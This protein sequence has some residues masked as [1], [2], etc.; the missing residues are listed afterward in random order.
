MT[1]EQRAPTPNTQSTPGASKVCAVPNC[2]GGMLS[3]RDIRERM[4]PPEKREEYLDSFRKREWRK[5]DG[6]G[7]EYSKKFVIDPFALYNLTPFSY[8][9]SIGDQVFSIQRPGAKVYPLDANSRYEMEP[10]ET[11]VV[12]TK[13]VIAIPH[14]YSATIW[15]RFNMVTKGLFQSMVKIDPT[16]Y[17]QIG[18]ALTNTSPTTIGL[19]RGEA[20]ATLLIYELVQ[21]SDVDLWMHPDLEWVDVPYPPKFQK[22]KGEFRKYV[23]ETNESLRLFCSVDVDKN[24]ISVKGLK[25]RQI[26]ELKAFE[27]NTEWWEFVD[28]LATTCAEALHPRTGNRMI[29]MD[30][31]GMKDLKFLEKANYG[32]RL[33]RQ[34]MADAELTPDDLLDA[35][36]RYGKPFHLLAQLPTMLNRRID[37]ET[38]PRIRAELEASIFPRIITL[39]FTTLGFLALIVAVLSLCLGHFPGMNNAHIWIWN[40]CVL[41][42]GVVVMV[43]LLLHSRLTRN[44]HTESDFHQ[45]LA[46]LGR[47][48]RAAEDRIEHLETEYKLA[49]RHAE[50][51]NEARLN[52]RLKAMED[53]QQR[54][55]KALSAIKK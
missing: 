45:R 40:I 31:L 25:R 18:V 4:V 5:I 11:V 55:K 43:G 22:W 30:S 7:A 13:E 35:A 49:N 47:K 38:A 37:T 28:Q 9:L 51:C 21:P 53:E 34:D 10:G 54:L 26:E 19:S 14:L 15:P 44:A 6:L 29:G 16:W 41:V 36:V 46:K 27:M 50:Q 1:E 20:F 33:D 42:I 48:T 3:G 17:G 23:F 12:I 24:M 8:D 52:K 39:T 2:T 32:K